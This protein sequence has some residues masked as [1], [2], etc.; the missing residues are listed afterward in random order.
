MKLNLFCPQGFYQ[1]QK[2]YF[3]K[4]R[5]SY[6]VVKNATILAEKS[7][8]DWAAFY[9]TLHSTGF[10]LDENHKYVL[11][12][13][14]RKYK[15]GARSEYIATDVSNVSNVSRK[16][17]YLGCIISHWGHF[18]LEGL[19]R[20]WFLKQLDAYK[21]YDLVYHLYGDYADK[22]FNFLRLLGVPTERLCKLDN[23]VCYEE[24]IVP[25]ISTEL[26]K[27]WTQEYK[28]T[29]DSLTKHISPIYS[30]KLY[31][32]R[33]KFDD[34][35]LG[36]KEIQNNFRKNGYRVVYPERLSFEKQVAL[37]KG[38]KQIACISGTTAHN[39]IFASNNIRCT[40]LER[41]GTPNLVQSFINEMRNFEVDYIKASYSFLP[42]AYGPGPF[43]VGVNRFVK[44]FFEQNHFSYN[45]KAD[46]LWKKF[47]FAYLYCWR[48]IYSDKE[49]YNLILFDHP[50]L[51]LSDICRK[52]EKVTCILKNV[53]IWQLHKDKKIKHLCF[54]F[55]RREDTAKRIRIYLGN[56]QIFSRK[57]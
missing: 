51:S 19:N 55:F 28:D 26:G 20:V 45:K 12:S 54:S 43:L 24:L 52:A 21:D 30:E 39:L 38:A 34:D 47:Y 44:S 6:E 18:I 33:L 42:T 48:K 41:C 40:I 36:E 57:K 32:S 17:I 29:I 2:T 15:S 25:E 22:F 56:I 10:V 5:I 50:Q 13:S 46:K 4:E 8:G 27:F 3:C 23:N 53:K 1:P 49:S 14:N 9:G 7:C 11:T 35:L 37:L 16:A 31:L